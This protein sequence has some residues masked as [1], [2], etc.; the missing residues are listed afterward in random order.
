MILFCFAMLCLYRLQQEGLLTLP[1]A[2]WRMEIQAI[3]V[4]L[5]VCAYASSFTPSKQPDLGYNLYCDLLYV[6]HVENLRVVTEVLRGCV[7]PVP[8][9]GKAIPSSIDCGGI[10][11]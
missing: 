6:W 8:G 4:R 1:M 9:P 5:P 7:Q 2:L 11:P 3:V 10:P